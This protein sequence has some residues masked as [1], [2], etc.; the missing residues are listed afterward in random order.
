[1]TIWL[2]AIILVLSLA[3]LGYRQGAIRVGFSLLGIMIGALLAVPLAKP[4]SILLKAFGVTHPVILWLVP[5][6]AVFC[7]INVIFKTVALL[8]H[9][10]TEV[11]FKYKA[12]D[13]RLSLWERMNRRVGLCL[14]IVNGMCYLVLISFVIYVLSYWTVQMETDSEAG[15]MV[16]LVN[17]MGKDLQSSGFSKTARALDR[18]PESYYAAADVAGLLFQNP[19]L[20]ARLARYPALLMLGERQEFR[21]LATDSD[22]GQKRA[23]QAPL[24]ELLECGSVSAIVNTPETLQNI[25]SI[26]EPDLK[27]LKVFLETGQSEKYSKEPILG[28][29]QLNVRGT[30]AAVRRAKPNITANAMAQERAKILW[31]FGKLQLVVGTGGQMVIKDFPN[32]KAAPPAPNA[33]VGP[34]GTVNPGARVMVAGS[35]PAP[36]APSAGLQSGSGSWTGGNGF[37][38]MTLSVGGGEIKANAAIEGGRMTLTIDKLALVFEPEF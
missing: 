19:L 26:V 15:K 30:L 27:D 5:P 29:W 33:P 36:Q 9:H 3:G 16:Q 13:L 8:V 28:R 6:V 17:R 32:L 35:A 2:L 11:Y 38:Q 34:G 31:M 25:W 21:T 20:E 1:M 14:G 10:K 24:A 4:M 37:Y 23:T 7:L 12:G 22:F 18:M